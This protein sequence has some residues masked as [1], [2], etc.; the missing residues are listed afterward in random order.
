MEENGSEY[1]FVKNAEGDVT[2]I[3]DENGQIKVKYTYDAWGKTITVK[4]KNGNDVSSTSFYAKAIPFRFRGYV[5]DY[6]SGLYYLNSRY[7][8]PETGR[9]INADSY[10]DTESGSPLSTNMFAYC[11]NNPVMGYDPEGAWDIKEH[12]KLC[13]EAKISK[14]VQVWVQTPDKYFSSG[15]DYI[16]GYEI[17]LSSPFHSRKEYKKIARYLYNKALKV[18][19]YKKH[20]NFSYRRNQ[21]IKKVMILVI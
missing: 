16:N 11:E 1:Y 17:N 21:K 6:E 20:V 5:Y 9:F 19:K 7:Y 13:R 3:I 8:D 12:A 14:K 18:K 2:A 4:D 15:K 10:V